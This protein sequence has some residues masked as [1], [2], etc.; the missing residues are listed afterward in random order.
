MAGELTSLLLNYFPTSLKTR[1]GT[2]I[3]PSASRTRLGW[4]A[5]G[6]I[7]DSQGS[8]SARVNLVIGN[9]ADQKVNDFFG[10]ILNAESY[11]SEFSVSK[12]F[13]PEESRAVGRVEKDT[14]KM[15]IGYEVPLL[16][17][18]GEPKKEDNYSVTK[19]R[20]VGLL[21]KIDLDPDYANNYRQSMAKYI[22]EG[23]ARRLEPN[24]LDGPRFSCH[25]MA[26]ISF[27]PN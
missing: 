13:T 20:F 7:G 23:Y 8:L 2:R 27:R 4:V 3:Q 1:E 21:R 11:A 24:E 17:C 22:S 9:K 19:K 5:T 12:Q 6:P 18:D 14:K 25:T 26:C 10:E 16:G 15:E